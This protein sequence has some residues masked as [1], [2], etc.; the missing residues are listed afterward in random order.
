MSLRTITINLG[1]IILCSIATITHASV[2]SDSNKQPLPAEKA[3]VYQ[4]SLNDKNQIIAHWDIAPGYYLYAE[5]FQFAVE[6]SSVALGQPEYPKPQ[7]TANGAVYEGELEIVIPFKT[8]QQ[9]QSFI[10]QTHYQGCAAIGLCYPPVL[11][12]NILSQRNSVPA[13]VE[14]PPSEQGF[15]VNLLSSQSLLRVL[16]TFFVLGI[17][18]AFTPC[19]L[20]M[21]PILSSIIVG[22]AEVINTT[23]A[24]R[25]SLTY[26]L[27]MAVAYAGLGA[28]AG[29]AG[30][31]LQVMF[32]YPA[33]IAA[34]AGLFILLAFSMF[35]LYE[36]KLPQFLQHKLTHWHAKQSGGDFYGA[37]G[38]GFFSTFLVSPCLTPALAAALLYLGNTGDITRGASALFAMGLGMGIPLIAVGILEGRFLPRTGTWMQAVKSLFGVLLLL[39]AIS[40]LDK[41]VS[42]PLILFLLGT[43]AIIFGMYSTVLF[44]TIEKTTHPGWWAFWRGVSLVLIAWGMLL[45]LGASAGSQEIYTPLKDTVFKPTS[46]E[47]LNKVVRSPEA[48]TTALLFAK[49]QKKAAVVNFTASWCAFCKN[50]E[51][52]FEESAL[53]QRHSNAIYWI[54]VDVSRQNKATK[55][56]MKQ[57]RISGPPTLL[58]FDVT[59][60]ERFELR[61][62]GAIQE[63]GFAKNLNTIVS[64]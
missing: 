6:D 59:G 22:E 23:R 28:L 44:P 35:G 25:L 31:N 60:Q 36:I 49:N 19:V 41:L 40:M 62:V 12:S 4:V 27:A 52:F 32:Q 21:I 1:L 33:A 34:F 48:L 10:L 26:V 47:Q 11:H 56:L 51:R 58:F 61:L 55:M 39:V 57:Y 7:Q 14:N 17:G 18:L 63:E 16:L 64:H 13:A 53:V 3:F 5:H 9:N 8:T 24:F 43:V 38:M 30:H 54:K 46:V 2:F 15:L 29:A 20:P 37:A 50:N 42:R 45:L